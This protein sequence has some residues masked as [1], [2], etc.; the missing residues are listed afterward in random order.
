MRIAAASWSGGK[1]SYLAFHT[2][3]ERGERILYTVHMRI[4]NIVSYHGPLSLIMAQQASLETIGVFVRTAWEEYERDFKA[5][6]ERLKR[7][8]VE[9]VVFGDIYIEDH[10]RWVERVCREIG[11]EALEPLWGADSLENALRA[12]GMGV[13]AMI[14]R[15]YDREPLSKYVGHLLDEEVIEALVKNG[16]DPSGEHGEY[17]TVVLDAPLFRYKIEVIDGKIETIEGKIR[18]KTYRYRVYIPTRYR[19]I[20]KNRETR[21]APAP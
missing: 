17:H 14:I 11:L 20:S 3:H 18:G 12:V 21:D 5:V 16:I 15:T 1:D 6:L 8:G 4:E 7:S 10:R 13:K 2:A 19:V 9:A